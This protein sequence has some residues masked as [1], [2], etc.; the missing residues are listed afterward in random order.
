MTVMWVLWGAMA[1]FAVVYGWVWEKSG[2]R[3]RMRLEWGLALLVSA[4]SAVS[5]LTHE[6][7]RDET[8]AWL[9]ARDWSV[10][11]LFVQMHYEGHFALWH[12]LLH[13]FARLGAGVVWTGWI[14]WAINAITVAWFARKAP[15]GGWAKAAA[16]LSCVFLY[17]NP[18]ISR[19]YVLVPPILFGLAAL[20]KVRDERPIAFGTLAALLANTHLYMEGT[21]GLLFLAYAWENVFRRHDGKGWRECGRQLAGLGLMGLGICAAMA[22]MVPGLWDHGIC[23]GGTGNGWRTDLAWFFQGCGSWLGAGMAVLGVVG[24]GVETWR[25]DRGAFTVH[26]GSLAYMAGFS[27]FL[28]PAHVLNRALLWYPLALWSAWVLGERGGKKAWLTVAVALIGTGLMRPDMT[29]LDWRKEYD[30]LPGACR[31]IAERY[32]RDAEVWVNGGDL[33]TEVASAYL[34]NVFDWRTGRRAER[35]SMAVKAQMPVQALFEFQDVHFLNHPE[36]DSVLVL[37]S[38]APW[39]GLTGE[40]MKEAGASVEYLSPQPLC[41]YSHQVFAMRLQ[42]GNPVERGAFWLRMGNGFLGR[43]ESGRAVAAWKLAAR[44]DGG[45]WEAMNNLAW[46]LAKAGRVGEARTWMDRAMEH[47]EAKVNAGVWDTEAAVK[48]AEGDEEGAQ[49]AE[50]RR[51]ELKTAQSSMRNAQ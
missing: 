19:C 13:P 5:V 51:D 45:Q 38:T 48:R 44:L 3:G 6:P 4:V 16:G 36:A 23:F 12:L 39:S 42:R 34:D 1:G 30:P 31:Y 15:V 33:C 17:V 10:P 37:G 9:L 8:H 2:P 27:V 32:G 50:R 26:A 11:E 49:A 7:W 28:Y 24:L 35:F 47:E 21:A 20:W 14:S 43:G 18:A 46:V 29:W 40:D 41:P 25:R 22:Q